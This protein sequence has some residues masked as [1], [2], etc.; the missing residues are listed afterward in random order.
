VV[1]SRGFPGRSI[2]RSGRKRDVANVK[3]ANANR[4]GSSPSRSLRCVDKAVWLHSRWPFHNPGIRSLRNAMSTQGMPPLP[5]NLT[6]SGVG[7]GP[8]SSPIRGVTV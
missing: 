3:A 8:K 4:P 7:C 5:S 6:L 1:R 2:V